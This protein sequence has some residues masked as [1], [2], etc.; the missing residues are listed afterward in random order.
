M[1]VY[2]HQRMIDNAIVAGD[3][4]NYQFDKDTKELKKKII[5]WRD[6]LPEHLPPLIP[7]EQAESMVRG[8]VQFTTLYLI[9]SDTPVFPIDPT[10]KNPCWAVSY[11]D[12][13]GYNIDVII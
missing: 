8:K 5:H 6:D 7:K 11:A 1:I 12:D 10:P 13:K 2:G 3:Y 4:I 9:L